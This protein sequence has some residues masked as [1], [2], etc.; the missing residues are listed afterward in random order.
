VMSRSLSVVP[1]LVLALGVFAHP[2]ALVPPPPGAAPC[3]SHPVSCQPHRPA[4]PTVGGVC[5]IAH[6]CRELPPRT[7]HHHRWH[8]HRRD[9]D[10]ARG[11]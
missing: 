3:W 2:N 8:H 11:L 4:P 1:A 5:S 9:W 6:G 7:R 10:D